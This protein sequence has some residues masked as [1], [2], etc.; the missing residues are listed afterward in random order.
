MDG[1]GS[2]NLG[3]ET[4]D[5]HVRPQA[6]LAGIGIVI[7]IRIS[8]PFRSPSTVSDPAAA[9]GQ[10]AGT[11]AGAVLSGATPLGALAGALGGKQLL[12][13]RREIAGRQAVPRRRVAPRRPHRSCKSFRMSGAC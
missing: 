4:L 6:R 11:V 7:P 9:I 5:L 12:G 1:G 10:N 3:A 2:L 8:G 13:D